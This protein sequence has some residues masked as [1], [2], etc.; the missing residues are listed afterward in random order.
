[1]KFDFSMLYIDVVMGTVFDAH[2]AACAFIPVYTIEKGIYIS[3]DFLDADKKCGKVINE[4]APDNRYFS[5]YKIVHHYIQQF[6]IHIKYL[7][8]KIIFEGKMD[9][10]R[11]NKMVFA[12]KNAFLPLQSAYEYSA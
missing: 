8:Q 7:T 3:T 4:I 1:M 12:G 2:I 9:I 6:I 5:A 10:I 11:H